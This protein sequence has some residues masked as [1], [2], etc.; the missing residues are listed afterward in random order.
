MPTALMKLAQRSTAVRQAE[1]ER[2]ELCGDVIPP[3]H[4]HLIDL[5]SRELMCACQACKILFDRK[6]AGGQHYRLVPDRRLRLEGFDLDD[7]GWADLRIPVEM[8]FFFES[9]SAGRVVAFYPSPLGATESLL[10]LEDWDELATANPVLGALEQDVE[11]L[12]VNRTRGARE[13]W[14][15]PVDRCYAL[16]GL[17]RTHWKGFAGGTEVWA[18]I[19]RFFDEM[20]ASATPVDKEGRKEDSWPGS[21][22]ESPM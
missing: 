7:A 12:L 1:L 11:A 21:R 17:I 8:A 22:S 6:A 13:S 16:V 19:D 2:C 18:E 9:S 3:E 15:V 20:R 5:E 4:R 14:L 10:E